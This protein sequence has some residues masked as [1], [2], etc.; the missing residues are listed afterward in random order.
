MKTFA[1]LIEPKSYF[2]THFRG[3]S[4]FGQL[5]WEIKEDSNLVGKKLEDLLANYSQ[6][7]FAVL[8]DPLPA[9]KVK[10][11]YCPVISKPSLPENFMCDLTDEDFV[12]RRKDLKKEKWAVLTEKLQNLKSCNWQIEEKLVKEYSEIK[13]DIPEKFTFQ[14]PRVKNSINRLTSSTGTEQF[15]PYSQD[16]YYFHPG[17]KLIVFL[18]IEDESLLEALIKALKRIG[19]F[20]YGKKASTGA[21]RF[22]VL[23]YWEFDLKSFGSEE[24]NAC[25]T[26][27]PSLP[28]KNT[29]LKEFFN[30]FVRFGKHG[31]R[32][33]QSSLPFKNP[34]LLADSGS[35]LVPAD[36]S[37]FNKS[38]LGTGIFNVSKIQPEAVMQGYTQFIP[39]QMEGC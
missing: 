38:Y 12:A 7:P 39:I 34:V 30:P 37:H 20:G 29:Y 26:L 24:P 2:C 11:R 15:A 25:L 3:D 23:D 1:V 33:G 21:G 17:I 8:S 16:E 36:Q 35:V 13:L 28:E 10:E 19:A 5:C 31:N 4:L 27:G 9:V 22:D 14:R 18:S 6:K 32:L